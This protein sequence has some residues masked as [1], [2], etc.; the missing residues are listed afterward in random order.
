[1]NTLKNDVSVSDE[2]QSLHILCRFLALR[3]ACRFFPV[4]LSV[5]GLLLTVFGNSQFAPYGIALIYLILPTFLS[6]SVK[7]PKQKENRDIP[8]SAL[9]K[10]YHYSPVLTT[11]YHITLTLCM[12]LLLVWHKVQH[13]PLT[14]LGISVP[15]IYLAL[16]LAFVPVLSRILFFRFHRRLMNGIL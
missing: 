7:Q 1:M 5:T 8:L 12:L 14:L 15:L 4:L 6:G 10:R 2:R 9:Y 16:C 13:T 11:S 3:T